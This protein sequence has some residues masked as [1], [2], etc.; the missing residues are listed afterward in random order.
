MSLRL[1]EAA[2]VDLPRVAE[3]F[4]ACSPGGFDRST[5]EAQWA[6]P[7]TSALLLEASGELLAGLLLRQVLDEAEILMIGSRWRR[8]GYGRRLIG[9]A[10]ARLAAAGVRYLHLEVAED[11]L[12]AL[13]LYEAEGF[14]PVGRRAGYYRSGAAARLYTLDLGA[15]GRSD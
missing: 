15:G 3:L 14:R 13:A 11:N 12:A 5:L 1:V 4:E 6:V 8:R 10:R 7:G 9:E 2:A